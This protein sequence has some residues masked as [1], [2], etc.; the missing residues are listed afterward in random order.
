[1]IMINETTQLTILSLL[2]TVCSSRLVGWLGDR[3]GEPIGVRHFGRLDIVLEFD[4]RA[5]MAEG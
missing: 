1:M 2:E 4:E 3:R 5:A